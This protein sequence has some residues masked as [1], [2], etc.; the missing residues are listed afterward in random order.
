MSLTSSL[1]VQNEHE[2]EYWDIYD[3]LTE[4]W[5]AALE[6][7]KEWTH[8]PE[9]LYPGEALQFTDGSEHSKVRPWQLKLCACASSAN[10]D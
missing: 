4:K 5:E 9:D 1:R 7:G 10:A 8:P 3:D 2:K 6:K